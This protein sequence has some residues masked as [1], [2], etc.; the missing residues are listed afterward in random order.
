LKAFLLALVTDKSG[1]IDE[2]ALSYLTVQ[3]FVFLGFGYNAIIDHHFD[4]VAFM[5]CEVPLV[6][7][8]NL[9]VKK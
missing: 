7:L 8:Y 5:A 2:A 4:G 1:Q 3:A 9:T 6:T